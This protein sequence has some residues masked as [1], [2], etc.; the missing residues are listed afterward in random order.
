MKSTHKRARWFVY[1]DGRLYFSTRT[2]RRVLF[3]LTL[4]MLAAG[5]LVKLGIV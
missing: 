4:V 2:E 1:E 5:A 3:V